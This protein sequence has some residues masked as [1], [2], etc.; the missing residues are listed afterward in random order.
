MLPT[1]SVVAI[2]KE[3]IEKNAPKLTDEQKTAI[4]NVATELA[5][6]AAA[7]AVQGA[8]SK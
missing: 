4:L 7:G 2:I 8:V 5:K 3:Q 6:A 1:A